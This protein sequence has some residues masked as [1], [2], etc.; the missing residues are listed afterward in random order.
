VNVRKSKDRIGQVLLHFAA[1]LSE[2]FPFTDIYSAP[3]TRVNC[4]MLDEM[5]VEMKSMAMVR[6]LATLIL[7]GT[8]MFAADSSAATTPA[9]ILVELF[10]SE[11]CSSC[12]PADALLQQLDSSQPISGAQLIVLSE[13]VTYWDHLGWKDPYSSSYVTERQANYVTRFSLASSYTP[14]MVVDGTTEFVGNNVQ[15]AKEALEKAHL[16]QKAPIHIS[17]ISSEVPGKLQA[18][19]EANALT[20]APSAD[21]YF[22][23]ALNHAESQVEKGENQGHH[24]TYV[25]V[26]KSMTKVG[27][28]DKSH[29][30]AKQIEV[31]LD[32]QTDL[33]NVRVI[34]FLQQRGSG[35]VIGAAMNEL[36]PA[37]K[38]AGSQ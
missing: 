2:L 1:W 22:V 14:E 32:P 18:Y 12:P 38:H 6:G 23:V 8:L 7:A 28:V 29:R 11:G 25:A 9:P 21:I 26:V 19:V 16:V 17:S 3:A 36:S 13:H 5:R 27:T 37:A 10:T 33:T 30:F 35:P 15:L 24:L 4:E 34:A 20:Q 31:K